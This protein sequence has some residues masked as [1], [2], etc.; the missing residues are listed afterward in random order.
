MPQIFK[1]H[2]LLGK[3]GRPVGADPRL[4]IGN[5]EPERNED[6]DHLCREMLPLPQQ[7]PYPGALTPGLDA[8]HRSAK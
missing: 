3:R 6:L 1:H 7:N 8:G 2:L 4:C 5:S